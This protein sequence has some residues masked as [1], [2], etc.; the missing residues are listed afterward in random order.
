MK[1]LVWLCAG[2]MIF[3]LVLCVIEYINERWAKAMFHLVMGI[4]MWYIG[5]I[6]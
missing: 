5:N 3:N 1:I 6:L 2:L 4:W